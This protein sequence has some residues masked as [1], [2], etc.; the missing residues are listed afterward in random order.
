MKQI[1]Q[2]LLG[3]ITITYVHILYRMYEVFVT[4]HAIHAPLNTQLHSS[5]N[6]IFSEV[7]TYIRDVV[8]KC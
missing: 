7:Y 3:H 2:D 5:I 6:Y 1:N 8:R 4:M